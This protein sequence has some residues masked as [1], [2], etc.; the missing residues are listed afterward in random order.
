MAH[1]EKYTIGNDSDIIISQ[2]GG[3]TYIH[4]DKRGIATSW[5]HIAVPIF[6]IVGVLLCGL[7]CI[8]AQLPS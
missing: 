3:F 1:A 6:V 4:K 8:V 2:K 5:R 7:L